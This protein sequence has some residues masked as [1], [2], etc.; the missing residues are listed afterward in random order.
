MAHKLVTQVHNPDDDENGDNGNK[1]VPKTRL[2]ALWSSCT[3][4]FACLFCNKCCVE[5]SPPNK[6]QQ[7]H[8]INN[9][10]NNNN[11]PPPQDRE[12]LSGKR[13]PGKWLLPELLAK[14]KGKRTLVLDLDETLVHSSFK[15]V[16]N[17]DFVISIEL[18][19]E[20]HHVYVLKRPGV[21]QFMK[22]VAEK[23]EVVVFT[24]SLAKYA[25]PLLDILDPQATVRHR[26]F[27][28]A[29]VQHYG[30]YVKDLSM[31]GRDINHV[32]IIDNSPYSY[33]F[34]PDN[35]V[36]IASW[37]NDP[38]DCQLMQLLPVLDAM[39][40]ADNVCTVI[41]NLHQYLQNMQNPAPNLTPPLLPNPTPDNQ[42]NLSQI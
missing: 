19:G 4:C 25:D 2:Q 37:F 36:P 23:F 22:A 41:Q 20:I 12:S 38:N 18:E 11:I 31:L 24:A 1:A 5:Q 26:L 17:A 30:N 33:I 7:N 15:P 34:Q 27:R 3:S 16:P 14:D 8:N 42:A 32:V 10:S 6:L 13:A 28:E 39:A 40:D 29:C 21:D 35:A 9:N